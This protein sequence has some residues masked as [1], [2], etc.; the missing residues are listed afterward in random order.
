MHYYDTE[1][2]PIFLPS[3]AESAKF[4]PVSAE[5]PPISS[6]RVPIGRIIANILQHIIT[7]YFHISPSHYTTH[8]RIYLTTLKMD[9]AYHYLKTKSTAASSARSHLGHHRW[10]ISTYLRRPRLRAAW[11]AEKI[12]VEATMAQMASFSVYDRIPGR[13][14]KYTTIMY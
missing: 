14:M 1:I 4:I 9:P 7:Y 6:G 11:A 10:Y 2:S 13:E 12:F 5:N 3:C 8:K